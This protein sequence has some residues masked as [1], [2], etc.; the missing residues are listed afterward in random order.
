[1]FHPVVDRWFR[2][3]FGAPAPAQERAWPVIAAGRDTLISAP[4]GAGKTLAAFL[5]CLDRLVRDAARGALEDRTDVLYISPLK[6]LSHDVHRAPHRPGA[7]R[8]QRKPERSA[9][10]CSA[11]NRKGGTASLVMARSWV[12]RAWSGRRRARYGG[13]SACRGHTCPSGR[14]SGPGGA[15]RDAL[16]RHRAPCGAQRCFSSTVVPGWESVLEHRS[17]RRARRGSGRCSGAQ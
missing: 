10:K 3:R 13:A 15:T 14:W 17:A 9:R 11:A 8:R 2:G 16:L 7:A 12:E 1:M 4:T 6:A 5:F